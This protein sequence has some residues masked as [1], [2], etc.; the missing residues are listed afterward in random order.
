M[1]SQ[2]LT[3]PQLKAL[4]DEYQ[5]DNIQL[6]D[7]VIVFPVTGMVSMK[8]MASLMGEVIV[9]V[10]VWVVDAKGKL[11]YN[12]V[13]AAK[14]LST[15]KFDLEYLRYMK[16]QGRRLVKNRKSSIG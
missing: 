10:E 5:V 11:V 15:A 12:N 7:S 2:V 4:K 14:D 16:L 3:L 8:V 13:F 6:P 1:Y 9:D